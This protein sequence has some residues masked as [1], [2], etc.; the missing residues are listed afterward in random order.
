MFGV[1]PYLDLD[2]KPQFFFVTTRKYYF[3]ELWICGI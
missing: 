2:I 1:A 3:N